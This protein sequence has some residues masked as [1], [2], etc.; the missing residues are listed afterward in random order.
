M[1]GK[2]ILPQIS[3]KNNEINFNRTMLNFSRDRTKKSIWEEY[4][5]KK[6][7]DSKRKKFKKI[8]IVKK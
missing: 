4:I 1:N 6:E 3:F 8:N 2:M 7:N 5:Q